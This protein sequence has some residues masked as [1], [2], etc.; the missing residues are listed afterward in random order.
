MGVYNCGTDWAG[1]EMNSGRRGVGSWDLEHE[2]ELI[3]RRKRKSVLM[4]GK[5]T[6]KV[7]EAAGRGKE[8][9]VTETEQGGDEQGRG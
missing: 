3:R 8:A 5:S 1:V 6:C 7:P 4:K 2:L 9:E